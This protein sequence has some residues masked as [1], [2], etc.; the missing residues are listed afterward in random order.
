[1]AA[2]LAIVGARIRTLDPARPFATA[3]AARGG[4]VVAVGGD[5]EIREHCDARTELLHAGGRALVPGLVD[6]H[7]HPFWGAELARGTDLSACRTISQVRAALSRAARTRRGGWVFAYGLDYDAAARELGCELIDGAVG[8]APAFVRLADM[9]TALATRRALEL[10][11]VDGPRAFADAS[12]VVCRDGRPTGELREHGAQQLV[13]AAAPPIDGAELRAQRLAVLRRQ[14]ALGLT[15]AHVMDGD[16][17]THDLLRELEGAGDLTL[18]LRVPL[19]QAPETTEDEMRAQLALRDAGGRLWRGGVAK[20]F[21]DGVIDSGTAWLE[22]P[23][24]RGAG[25]EPFWPQPERLARAIELFARAGFQCATHA[26][27]DRAARFTLGAYLRAGAAPGVRHRLEHLETLPD[28]L[29][30]AI[31]AAGVV[32]SMQPVHLRYVRGDGSGSWAARL[33]PTRAARAFRTRDLLDRG[34]IL[35]LGSD[36]PV[37]DDDPRLGMA[38]ARLRRLP[39]APETHAVAPG[40]ALTALEAL[41][42]YTVA[43]AAAAGEER[44]A[45]RIRRGM[46][47][48]LTGFATDPVELAA[49]ELPSVPVWLTVVG[50]RIVHRSELRAAA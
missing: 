9:H 8:G 6:A 35:A 37:A 29:V 18:R 44:L 34:A 28:D 42:G 22:Q 38:A 41:E 48:D 15:G 43:C 25:T 45:G 12:Q 5:A 23:D 32:A 21:A 27:G 4:I 20:F 33:G 14:N 40:Q 49:A 11:G 31:A 2:E 36:W 46:R 47:A 13:L 10:A 1:M 39:D 7:L 19:L 30:A 3:L 16:P 50:G 26:I 24:S 17:E